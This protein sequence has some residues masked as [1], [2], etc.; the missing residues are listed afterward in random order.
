MH[1]LRNFGRIAERE[2]ALNAGQIKLLYYT[3]PKDFHDEYHSYEAPRLCTIIQGKKSVRVNQSE[4]FDYQSDEF[5]LLSPNSNIHMKMPE[6]TKALVYEF[7]QLLIEKVAQRVS[8]YLEV[9]SS[10]SAL[11]SKSFVVNPI[12]KRVEALHKRMLDILHEQE[13]GME[14]LIELTGQ[15]LVFELLRSNT[16]QSIITVS[17]THPINRAIRLMSSTEGMQLSL[18]QVAEEVGMSLSSFSQRFKMMTEQTPKQYLT[19]ARL[20]AAQRHLSYMSVTDAAYETGYNNISHFIRLF[21][22]E[23]GQTPKQYQHSI[24]RLN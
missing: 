22:G 1:A 12:E 23:F 16:C 14:F 24:K 13:A 6:Y 11:D 7:N 17:Q 9:D 15:E 20:K 4:A 8:D 5:V 19:Q 2:Y 21:K 18:S 3:L 10:L